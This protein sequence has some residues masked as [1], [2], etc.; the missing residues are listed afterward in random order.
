[1]WNFINYNFNINYSGKINNF[2]DSS[3]KHC[4]S[5]PLKKTLLKNDILRIPKWNLQ[6]SHSTSLFVF[7]LEFCLFLSIIILSYNFGHYKRKNNSVVKTFLM[8]GDEIKWPCKIGSAVCFSPEYLFSRNV[9]HSLVVLEPD[10]I[11][12]QETLSMVECR[13]D[14]WD[15][16]LC[17]YYDVFLY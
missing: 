3:N 5:H 6:K 10:T 15:L 7:F 1:M 12:D 4:S 11:L 8:C 9:R 2:S 14:H 16:N 17:S 13:Y